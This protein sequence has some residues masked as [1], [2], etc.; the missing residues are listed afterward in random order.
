MSDF[1]QFGPVTAIP[2]LVARDTDEME[3][4]M[5]SLSGRFPV[6][7]VI[8]LVPSEMERPALGGILD[9]LCRVSYLD[10]LV[11][12]LNHASFDDYHRALAYF[13]RYPGRKVVLWNESPAVES[14]V[15]EMASAGLHTGE[16]GRGAPA[17]WPS[18][19]CWPRSAP[20]TSPSRT[21][22]SS[23]SAA[24]CSPGW[25]YRRSS[26]PWTSTSS[27]PTTRASPTGS[28]GA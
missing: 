28:M 4:R 16:P 1:H 21:R 8:P 22:T 24:P 3:R 18:A 27:R 12:S 19:R 23:T 17:G 14:F 25:S 15:E 11:L 13:E 26:P 2:L 20:P 7:L 10:S 9:E 6:S 5:E